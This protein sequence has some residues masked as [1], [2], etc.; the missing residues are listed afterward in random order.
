MKILDR[1]G[2]IIT[3]AILVVWLFL[4]FNTS[5][6][7]GAYASQA[8]DTLSVYFIGLALSLAV[9]N[10]P[11][12]EIKM[13]AFNIFMFPV[14]F[15]ATTIFATTIISALVPTA[16]LAS[17]ESVKVMAG[18][19]IL[20]SLVKAFIEEVIF[21]GLIQKYTGNF[22]Q[23]GLFSI[24][25]VSMLWTKFTGFG[26]ISAFIMLFILGYIWGETAKHFGLFASTGSHTAWNA[27]VMG[28]TGMFV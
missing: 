6:I 28:I 1:Q 8:K 16:M 17:F 10:S 20:Y 9:L 25:H 15:I 7:F 26:I 22:I 19:G 13:T 14:A 24:F 21:R 2:I 3:L 4:W 27:F 12:P 18:F 5:W 23:A 11:L